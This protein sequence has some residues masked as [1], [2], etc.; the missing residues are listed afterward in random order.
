[1]DRQCEQCG[2]IHDEAW[3]MSYNTG[4]TRHWFCWSCWKE[5]QGEAVVVE[6]KRKHAT[7][8]EKMKQKG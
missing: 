8:K 1:M 2:E 7:I 4:R 5:G 3:M 6:M